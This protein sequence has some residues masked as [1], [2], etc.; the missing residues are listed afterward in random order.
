MALDLASL[1][2]DVD[3]LRALMA[4]QAAALADKDA[5]LVQREAELAGE[6]LLVE[7]LR[8]QL[9]CLR[10]MQF[11]RSSERLAAEADQLELALEELEAGGGEQAAATAPDADAAITGPE[12]ERSKPARRPLPDH[13]P[14][15]VIE[16]APP[17]ACPRCGGVLRRLGEYVTE[18][19]D[20]VPGSFRVTRHAR[21]KLSCRS[22][23][24]IAQAPAPSLPIRRGRAGPGLL[25]RVLV[26]KYADHLPLY[27]QS[28][29]YA[30]EGWRWTA[31]RWPTG[32]GRVPRCCGRWWTRWRGTSWR[33]QCCMPTTRRCRC[34]HPAR[35]RRAPAVS[36]PTCAT[37]ARTAAACCLRCSTVTPRTAGGEHPRAH[38]AGFRG[39]LHADGYTGLDGLY[40]GGHVSEVACWAHVR[41]KFFDLHAGG[42]SPLATEAVRRIG[43]LYDVERGIRGRPPDERVRARQQHAQP[44][45][46]DLHAWLAATLGRIPGRGDLAAAIRYALSRWQALTRYVADG[47]LETDNNAVERAIRPLTLG[48][49]NWLFAGSDAGGARAAAIAALVG[50]A[51]LNGLDPEAYLRHVLGC[52]AEQPVNHIADL[53]PWNVPVSDD[54]QHQVASPAA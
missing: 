15:D 42:T 52:I 22:C 31:P 30:R 38:L 54:H 28:G 33:A 40:E 51:K 18:V 50:T 6:R 46:D 12:P 14:R 49:K 36:G 25:A 29:I 21:P 32:S 26:A 41:R 34:W 35:A 8:V 27:R 45:L 13:L 17:C 4:A 3:A 48:R 53:L 9:D 43:L 47:R 11:G 23:E 24:A 7:R 19:L 44:V 5:A 10:R 39:A 2:D 1:P 20:W 16:H 37:S